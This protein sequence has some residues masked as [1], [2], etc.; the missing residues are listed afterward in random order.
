MVP[1]YQG[2][3]S[4][5]IFSKYNNYAGSGDGDG[6]NKIALLDPNDTQIDPHP[7]APGLVEMREVLTVIGPT[8][9][10]N[11]ISFEF[12]YAVREYCINTTASIPH[13]QYLHAERGRPHLLL[14]P[15]PIRLPAVTLRMVSGNVP[16]II[17]PMELC[18]RL[19]AGL[20]LRSAA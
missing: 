15:S 7:S 8:P 18:I 2:T 12:P 9:D 6:V 11:A 14:D 17:G 19:M 16:T 4:Y 10:A 5:L 1:S 13:E 3:S 20:S